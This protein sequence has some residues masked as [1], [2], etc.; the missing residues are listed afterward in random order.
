MSK[1]THHFVENYK[2]LVGFGLDRETDENTIICY[3]Q[4]FSD[5]ILMKKLVKS[6]TDKELEDLFDIFNKLLKNHLSENEYHKLFLK[7]K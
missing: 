1:Y 5:D 3:A 7:N 2:D 4:M 6:M